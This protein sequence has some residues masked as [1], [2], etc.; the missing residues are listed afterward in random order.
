MITSL[1]LGVFL[2][3]VNLI[4]GLI[5]NVPTL[6]DWLDSFLTLLSRGLGFFPMDVW[7]I[8]IIN[9]S[10]WLTIQFVW[11]IIEWV[12]IKIPGVN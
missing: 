9:I 8:L 11:S 6:P 2:S 5:P 12:Y 3:P 7:V 4:L 1:I 10:G